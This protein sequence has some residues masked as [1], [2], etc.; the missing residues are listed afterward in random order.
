VYLRPVSSFHLQNHL[1][2]RSKIPAVITDTGPG[3]AE[4]NESLST[5][6]IQFETTGDSVEIFQVHVHDNFDNL[7]EHVY[8]RPVSSFHLQ[9]HLLP[10]SKGILVQYFSLRR[11]YPQF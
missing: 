11:I 8:L 1:L 5:E 10:R 7:R 2:P 4:S 6:E 3:T 9:N